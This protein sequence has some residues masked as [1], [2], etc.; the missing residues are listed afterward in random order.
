MIVEYGDVTTLGTYR[1][2]FIGK[3]A[4]TEANLSKILIGNVGNLFCKEFE[5]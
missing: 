3:M 2:A 4:E 5:V 1:E